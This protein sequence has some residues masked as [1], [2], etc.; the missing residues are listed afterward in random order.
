MPV[1]AVLLSK[2]LAEPFFH[3]NIK[4]DFSSFGILLQGLPAH[5][6]RSAVQEKSSTR[7]PAVTWLTV[8]RRFQLLEA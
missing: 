7:I 2:H 1:G 5:V 6:P 8:Y 3:E 4:R